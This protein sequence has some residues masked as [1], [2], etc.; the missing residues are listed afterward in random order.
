MH[1]VS[2]A[3]SATMTVARYIMSVGLDRVLP[4][5]QHVDHVDAD[6]LNDDWRNLQL[7]TVAENLSK[8]AG[9][10]TR[11][12]LS[13]TC[14]VCLRRKLIRP[15]YARLEREAD[16]RVFM[17]SSRC[18]VVFNH[19]S[20]AY[21]LSPIVAQAQAINSSAYVTEESPFAQVKATGER[22]RK[23]TPALRTVLDFITRTDKSRTPTDFG[24][25]R[26]G[27]RL[28]ARRH[29]YCAPACAHQAR[30]DARHIP[31]PAKP[32]LRYLVQNFSYCALGRMYGVSDNAVRKWARGYGL[33]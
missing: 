17:C 14:P 26:C 22:L 31:K 19:H 11:K 30:A 13:F 28:K 12:M 33:I 27:A 3:A 16:N 18:A 25:C 23:M 1:L 20:K 10:R 29:Q 15:K 5:T 21:S 24:T 2:G 6:G 9:N 32:E 4:D 8:G 7:L